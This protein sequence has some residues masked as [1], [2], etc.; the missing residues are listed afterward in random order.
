MARALQK[1]TTGDRID[2]DW[3]YVLGCQIPHL[4]K[5]YE[6][7]AAYS[8]LP[9][10]HMATVTRNQGGYTEY[11]VTDRESG[12]VDRLRVWPE[13]T[14]GFGVG[15]ACAL[16]IGD[17]VAYTPPLGGQF[18]G[19]VADTRHTFPGARSYADIR[20]RDGRRSAGVPQNT[21]RLLKP[22]RGVV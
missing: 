6:R 3:V 17:V 22:A 5:R 21:L 14:C 20:W 7:L 11:E 13:R 2:W 19:T 8:W 10:R 16:E 4:V 15:H 18:I 9:G 1:R 12:T